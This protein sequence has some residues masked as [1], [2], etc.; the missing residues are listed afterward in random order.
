MN[1]KTLLTERLSAPPAGGPKEDQKDGH[2][3]PEHETPLVRELGPARVAKTCLHR[4]GPTKQKA[5]AVKQF[6]NAHK[7]TQAHPPSNLPDFP[8]DLVNNPRETFGGN[9]GDTS[10]TQANVTTEQTLASQT[11][12]SRAVTKDNTRWPIPRD[13]GAE[14]FTPPTRSEL[15]SVE[16]A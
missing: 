9:M 8:R 5:Q 3:V 6:T 14:E 13:Q 7:D 4:Y 1:T 11:Q 15:T 12:I 16:K 2:A 10:P